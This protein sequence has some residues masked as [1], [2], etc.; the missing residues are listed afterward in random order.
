MAPGFLIDGFDG[1]HTCTST[2][3]LYHWF[4]CWPNANHG[5]DCLRML[6]LVRVMLRCRRVKLDYKDMVIDNTVFQNVY[7]TC[8]TWAV[9][10][11][12]VG[13]LWLWCLIYVA[14]SRHDHI[15]SPRIVSDK[16]VLGQSLVWNAADMAL[17]MLER[18]IKWESMWTKSVHLPSN[19]GGLW[20]IDLHYPR[21]IW[22]ILI[23]LLSIKNI[24]Q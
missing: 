16:V 9:A 5:W 7:R 4:C 22:R 15:W 13:W 8:C 1:G 6:W 12:A 3:M 23:I 10:E 2:P 19:M 17:L 20:N 24:S 21:S 14:L 11:A 18:M